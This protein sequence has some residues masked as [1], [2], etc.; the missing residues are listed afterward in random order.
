MYSTA[1]RSN[2]SSKRILTTTKNSYFN[3]IP[4][5]ARQEEVER[6]AVDVAHK[7]Q[8]TPLPHRSSRV[9]EL[10]SLNH[11]AVRRG[12]PGRG[13]VTKMCTVCTVVCMSRLQEYH[14]Q[15]KEVR[16]R[17]CRIWVQSRYC[18]QNTLERGLV[19]F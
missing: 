9:L 4:V 7:D 19:G 13:D 3:R 8:P 10:E 15:T 11:D 16:G 14:A 5:P 12:L 17:F 2:Y 1:N 18:L 6:S